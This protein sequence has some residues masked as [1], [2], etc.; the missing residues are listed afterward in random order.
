MV[1]PSPLSPPGPPSGRT[2]PPP[3]PPNRHS[4]FTAHLLGM[5]SRTLAVSAGHPSFPALHGVGG[6]PFASDGPVARLL[7]VILTVL[8]EGDR[9]HLPAEL[10]AGKSRATPVTAGAHIPGPA[11][12]RWV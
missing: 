8:Q 9:R 3:H 2:S 5:P 4:Q 10:V 12:A 7:A 6:E 11:P 1:A